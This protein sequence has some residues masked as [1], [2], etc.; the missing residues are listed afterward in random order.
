M[1][2]LL[3]FHL[4]QLLTSGIMWHPPPLASHTHES[5]EPA[6]SVLLGVRVFGRPPDEVWRL[7]VVVF[8]ARLQS[9]VQMAL[10]RSDIYTYVPLPLFHQWFTKSVPAASRLSDWCLSSVFSH[11]VFTVISLAAW[12]CQWAELKGARMWP[13]ELAL[14][15]RFP[16]LGCKVVLHWHFLKYI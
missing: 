15:I 1:L 5:Y 6:L 7:V 13:F 3:F 4:L 14:M 2:L 8:V 11:C 16:P 12:R 10:H 9:A